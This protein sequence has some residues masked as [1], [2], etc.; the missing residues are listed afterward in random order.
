MK[1]TLVQYRSDIKEQIIAKLNANMVAGQPLDSVKTIVYGD[2]ANFANPQLP[3]VWII[4]QSH[5]PTVLTGNTY[6]HDFT[7]IFAALVRDSI[8][9]SGKEAAEELAAKIFDVLLQDK[10]LNNTV[11]DVVPLEVSPSYEIGAQNTQTYWAAVRIAFK[12]VN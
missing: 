5:T 4:P 10:T 8:P 9:E 1:K 11:Y 6:E 12:I 7:F 3:Q 2:R